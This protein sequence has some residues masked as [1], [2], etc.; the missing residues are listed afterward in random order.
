MLQLLAHPDRTGKKSL[1]SA[2]D[3]TPAWQSDIYRLLMASTQVSKHRNVLLVGLL[4]LSGAPGFESSV[5]PCGNLDDTKASFHPWTF[6]LIHWKSE[7]K[8]SICPAC[9][10]PQALS[11]VLKQHSYPLFSTSALRKLRSKT[12]SSWHGCALKWDSSPKQNR[13]L[14]SQHSWYRAQSLGLYPQHHITLVQ[15]CSQP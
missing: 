13:G 9:M 5:T 7:M 14:E 10:R 15:T 12:L 1:T 3:V 11:L 4:A 8:V 2:H 6:I